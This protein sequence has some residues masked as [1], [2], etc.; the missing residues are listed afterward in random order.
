MEVYHAKKMFTTALM[1]SS[2]IL[3]I[4]TVLPLVT[5]TSLVGVVYAEGNAPI[6]DATVTVTGS[7]ASGVATTDAT[8]KYTIASGLGTGT[9][10]ITVTAPGYIDA[11]INIQVTAGQ[12]ATA[13]TVTMKQ[14]GKISGVVVSLSIAPSPPPPG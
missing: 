2:L 11:K 10:T 7:N 5:Q 4:A 9:A 1:L 13:P 3:V 8:G 6:K 12:T 14:S